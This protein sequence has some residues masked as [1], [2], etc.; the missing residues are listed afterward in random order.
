MTRPSANL[1]KKMIEAGIQILN[2]EGEKSLTLRNV[3]S[4]A[5][6]NPGMF[7]YYFKTKDNFRAII[8]AELQKRFYETIEFE[9]VIHKSSIEQLR[10]VMIKISEYV[11]N[12]QKLTYAIFV[13]SI[14][15]Y[16][17]YLTKIEKGF[18]PA[19]DALFSLI[20]KAK[21]DGFMTKKLTTVQIYLT[22]LFGVIT[23]EFFANRFDEIIWEQSSN[24]TK[25]ADKAFYTDRIDIILKGLED[26]G[27]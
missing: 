26:Y 11:R 22:L 13:N 15:N 12:N 17:D 8:Y 3:C 6:A 5:N 18:F 7:P 16:K 25:D 9:K 21:K 4:K 2:Q 24:T 1:D 10:Y 20:D 19:N 23:P 27:D 14:T